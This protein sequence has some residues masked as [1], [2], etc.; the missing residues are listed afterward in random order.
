MNSIS[1]P[2]RRTVLCSHSGRCTQDTARAAEIHCM[3]GCKK[4]YKSTAIPVTVKYYGIYFTIP[5]TACTYRN[6]AKMF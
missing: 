3:K 4:R 6:N 1:P 2:C 5:E